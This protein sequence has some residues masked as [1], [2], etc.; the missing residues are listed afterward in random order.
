MDRR[1]TR[2]NLPLAVDLG[3]TDDGRQHDLL[4]QKYNNVASE[5]LETDTK[6][7]KEAQVSCDKDK[8]TRMVGRRS[9]AIVAAFVVLLQLLYFFLHGH[10]PKNEQKPVSVINAYSFRVR[11]F[12]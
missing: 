11:L 6:I 9:L 1:A 3:L 4:L 12:C 8:A 2:R 7:Q 10:T 5:Y